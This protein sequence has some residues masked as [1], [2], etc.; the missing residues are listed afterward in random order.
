MQLTG[1]RQADV[2]QPSGSQ[3]AVNRQCSGQERIFYE[4]A[5]P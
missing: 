5:T 2:R 3:Q 1:S 4:V